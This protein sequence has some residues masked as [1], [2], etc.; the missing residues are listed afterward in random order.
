M[1]IP[2]AEIEL[3]SSVFT[4]RISTDETF[5]SPLISVTTLSQINSILS[6]ANA[7]SCKIF[8]AL[9][10]SRLWTIVT[11]ETRL[12]RYSAS[13]TAESPP[14]TTTTSLFLKKA[15]SQTAQ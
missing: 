11:L 1:N 9:N 2:S 4:L 10:S 5:L 7:L 3:I 12:D 13:S 8:C 6:F 14:P 15:P